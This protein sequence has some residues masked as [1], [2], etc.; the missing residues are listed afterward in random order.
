MTHPFKVAILDYLDRLSDAAAIGAV[1]TVVF[2]NGQICE[3][4]TDIWSFY[5]DFR[6]YMAGAS[7]KHV[8]LLGAGVQDAPWPMPYSSLARGN[9]PFMIQNGKGP[10]P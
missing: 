4:N 6:D 2:E 5:D 7:L 10:R 1:N 8:L 3:R 9:C